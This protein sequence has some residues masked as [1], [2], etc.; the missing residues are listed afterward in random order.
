MLKVIACFK[1]VIDEADIRVDAP[2]RKLLLE[3][4]AFKISPYDRNAVEEAM[5]LQEQHGASVTAVTVAPASAKNCLKDVLSRGPDRAV[6]VN[7]PSFADLEPARTT[8]LL[9]AAIGSFVEFDL[10]LCGE[11]SSD[12][13]A[14]QVG[15]AL[16]EK[17]GIAC[18]TYVNKLT[19][20]EGENRVIAERKLEEG[21]EVVSVPLPGLITVLPD[22][23]TP[24]IPSLKQVLG[25]AKKPVEQLTPERLGGMPAE[26]LKTMGV[27]AATMERKRLRFGAGAEEIRSVVDALL[28]E[29]A[30]G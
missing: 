8:G 22:I 28:K 4:A 12:L 17:L 3:R 7:D 29:G 1:W 14:Q 5:R 21:I 13:Y 24:R 10:I 15:P 2:N 20:V 25:A 18:A 16:A 9:A 6:F 26:R 23:N 11:G 27:V 19:Y 30:I